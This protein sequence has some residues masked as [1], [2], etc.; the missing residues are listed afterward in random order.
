MLNP[1]VSLDGKVSIEKH[2]FGQKEARRELASMIILHEYPLSMVEHV[3]FRRFTSSLQPLFKRVS[4]NTIKKEIFEIYNFDKAKS[5]SLLEASKSQIALTT[6]M[7]TSSNQNKGF[8][9]LTA[10]FID[11][12]WALQNWILSFLIN[13]LIQWWNGIS[14]GSTVN[15][16][17]C[18][19]N[20]LMLEKI[21]EKLSKEHLVLEGKLLHMRCATHILNLIVRYGLDVIGDAIE[22]IRDNVYYWKVTPKRSEEFEKMAHKVLKVSSTKKLILDCRTKWNST[23]MMLDVALG[24][25]DVF[26]SMKLKDKKYVCKPGDEDWKLAQVICDK[27]KTF[28]EVCKLKIDLTK[29]KDDE[30]ETVSSMAIS[31]LKKFNK[32]WSEVNGIMVV[33]SFLDPRIMQ[34]IRVLERMGSHQHVRMSNMDVNDH[35]SQYDEFVKEAVS[36]TPATSKF[37]KYK[38]EPVKPRTA[39]FDVLAWWKVNARD[40]PT[41]AIIAL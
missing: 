23:Y 40:F 6:D 15:V 33:A 4:R 19:T 21:E 11:D 8:M 32:F 27:L 9:V 41:L 14:L 38:N 34:N 29:W 18:S 28:Y 17:N 13:L 25:K 7:W 26:P 10:H 35:L 16:D 37:M 20:D 1:K 3:S 12:S 31:M 36:A 2:T 39:D 30:N 24:Y 5:L 22:K